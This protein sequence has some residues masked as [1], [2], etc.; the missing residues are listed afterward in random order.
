MKLIRGLRRLVSVLLVLVAALVLP[1]ALSAG[2][3]AAVV[4]DTDTYV[5]TVGPLADEPV[6][7]TALAGRIEMTLIEQVDVPGRSKRL[8]AVIGRSALAPYLRDS[9]DEV[10]PA[11]TRY[12]ADAAERSVDSV[13]ESSVFPDLWRESNRSAHETLLALLEESPGRSVTQVSIDLRPVLDAAAEGLRE[14]GLLGSRPPGGNTVMAITVA[15]SGELDTAR[16]VYQRIAAVG[17]WLPVTVAALLV[18]ALVVSPLRRRTVVL[19]ASL[20]LATVGLLALLVL[21]A[22]SLLDTGIDPGQERDVVLVVWDVLVRSL[23]TTI[24]VTLTVS[25]LLVLVLMLVPRIRWMD[26]DTE[27]VGTYTTG[28]H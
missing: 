5:E 13:M 6:V 22:R 18:V 27:Q 26:R 23:W 19:M 21:A 4:T 15:S 16:T 28:A 24:A 20:S 7:R 14:Q 2:W 11:L 1:L 12:V 3:L 8:Q 17:W 10:T 9:R 25:A